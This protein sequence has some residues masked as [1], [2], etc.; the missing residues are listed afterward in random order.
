MYGLLMLK[1]RVIFEE[2]R[3]VNAGTNYI[4]KENRP[5]VTGGDHVGDTRIAVDAEESMH[6]EQRSYTPWA[7]FI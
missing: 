4:G 6:D 2:A 3:L 5:S 7:N 1:N